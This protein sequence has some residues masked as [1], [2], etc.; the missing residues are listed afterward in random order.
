MSDSS[1]FTSFVVHMSSHDP[2]GQS[3]SSQSRFSSDRD[4]FH[5]AQTWFFTRRL[6]SERIVGQPKDPGGHY[7]SKP[8]VGTGLIAASVQWAEAIMRKIDKVFSR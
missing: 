8:P 1:L 5:A 2:T 6:K 3:D 7:V 4:H